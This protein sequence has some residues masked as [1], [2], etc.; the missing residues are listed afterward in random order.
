MPP[1]I[2]SE[3]LLDTRTVCTIIVGQ[4]L[5]GPEQRF[6]PIAR[7]MAPRKEGKRL[8]AVMYRH[9]SLPEWDIPRDRRRVNH[10]ANA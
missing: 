7:P 2:A 9:Q 8:P 3:S 1:R 6:L 5:L 4:E 10:N